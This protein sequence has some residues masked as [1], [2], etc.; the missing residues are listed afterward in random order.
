MKALEDLDAARRKCREEMARQRERHAEEMAERGRIADDIVKR[1]SAVTWE[2]LDT[3][4]HDE[5]R[6]RVCLDFCP[7]TVC[8]GACPRAE[9]EYIAQVVAR[10]VEQTIRTSKFIQ[11]ANDNRYNKYLQA[12]RSN[13]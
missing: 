4:L 13:P 6:Y 3:D 2:R 9:Q 8:H 12:W 5:M 11:K 10:D 1:L 7:S